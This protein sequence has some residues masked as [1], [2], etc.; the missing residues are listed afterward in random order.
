MQTGEEFSI[1]QDRTDIPWGQ[2]WRRCIDG[3]LDT[4]AF[5]IPIITPGFFKSG[6]CRDEFM[7]FRDRERQLG[8]E[9][10]I[11]PIY[12]VGCPLLDDEVKRE[13]D[14][15]ART[16]VARNWTDWRELRFEPLRSPQ[17]GKLLASMA[18][19]IVDAA[20]RGQLKVVA[21]I[22][23]APKPVEPKIAKGDVAGA[24]PQS[25]LQDKAPPTLSAIVA[26]PTL[27][28]DAFHRG[29]YCSIGEALAA[30]KPGDRILVRPGLYPEGIVIQKPVEIIGDGELGEIVVEAEGR[31]TVL[32]QA[33]MGRI[34]NLTLRQA[35]GQGKWCCVNIAQGRLDLEDCDITSLNAACVVIHGN[36]DPRIRRNRI[37]D[38]KSAG[39]LVYENGRG[40]L[41]DNDI[42]GNAHAGVAI[43]DGGDPILRRNRIHDGKVGGV[44]VFENGRGILEDNEIFGNAFAGVEIREGGDPILRRNGI[45]DGKQAGLFVHTNGRGTLEDNHIFGNM[46][47]GVDIREGGNPLLRSNR[48]NKNYF[49][50]IS[51]KLGGTGTFE[52]NDL[53]G[54]GKGPWGIV[55]DAKD[56]VIRKDNIE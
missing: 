4:S 14:E 6:P 2:N 42:F 15:I 22:A 16:V 21:A 7:Q 35:A 32:F 54:N 26:P 47:S 41:E 49:Q 43:K 1:F 52:Y 36:A 29:D 28:V 25:T 10:L 24:N 44:F 34:A 19:N 17:I 13:A 50:A 39:I 33:S 45:Y 51:I 18:K 27:V 3:T 46:E 30:A 55:A 56:K 40:T 9:D 53:R 31:H 37:H 11:F 48:I 12:Y 8:R 20:E 23:P 38:G 5:L